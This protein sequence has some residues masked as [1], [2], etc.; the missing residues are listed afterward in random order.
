MKNYMNSKFL[1]KIIY[2][3]AAGLFLVVTSCSSE[4]KVAKSSLNSYTVN[5]IV[6]EI[7]ENHFDFDNL[8]AKLSI[9]LK[10]DNKLGLKGQIRIQNDSAIWMSL[11][12]KVGIEVARVMIT[13]DSI[14]YINRNSR[15]YLAESLD[16]FDDKLPF[17]PSLQ[18][19][20]DIL[21]GNDT[22]I[23]EGDKYRLSTEDDKYKLEITKKE[24]KQIKK[25][26][27]PHMLVKDVWIVPQTFK[28]SKYN[29]R[30]YDNDKRK[31]QLQYDNFVDIN[32]K[33]MPSKIIFSMS[34]EY[35]ME[36]EIDYSNINE[37]DKL[38]F[39]FNISS[40]LDKIYLW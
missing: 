23:K 30:E 8:E 9:R 27:E 12:L 17:K 32:G 14:K 2:L 6:R 18:M 36:L 39:P 37:A 35:D 19:I 33:L 13:E 11:S 28:I 24:K 20:Q 22:Q 29:I 3:F 40:K 25:I 1:Y 4:K 34:S 21:L 26:A 15:I 5:H 31:V 16:Y 7:E 38:E 10:G